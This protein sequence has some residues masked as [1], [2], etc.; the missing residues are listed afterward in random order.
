RAE[1]G[2][3]PP[4][5]DEQVLF[6]GAGGCLLYEE[7]REK[8]V[9]AFT[10]HPGVGVMAGLWSGGIPFGQPGDQRIDEAHSLVYTTTPLEENI[11]IIGRPR[12]ILQVSSSATVI[13]FCASLCDVAP[14][15][16]SHLVAKGM[17]NATRR[18][19][20]TDPEPLT[21]GAIYTLDFE[22]DATA[23]CFVRGHRIRLD[24]A[25]ADFPNVWPTPEPSTNRIYFGADL[26]RIYLPVVPPEG[27]ASPPEFRPSRSVGEI[28]SQ[29]TC[30]PRWEIK[31]D[32]LTDRRTVHI[33]SQW[34][35]RIN[36]TTVIECESLIECQVL[37]SDPAQANARGRY[38]SRI[39]RPGW[40]VEGC[41]NLSIIGAR[42]HLH[43]TID[44]VIHING[45]PHFSR[46]WI[47]SVPRNLL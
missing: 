13:G 32:L 24:I 34:E 27:S 36:D 10:Y 6:L 42:S 7:P 16:T 15:G 43:I 41:S 2:W 30:V 29:R 38:T 47:Q 39:V 11:T 45:S 5:A 9:D 31:H 14:D 12:I 37:P 44:L 21:P 20:L 28:Q 22:I 40:T 8:G 3:P 18:H 19:S 26:S 33:S 25:S 1:T 35:Y 4:D 46:R 23:W 17:L